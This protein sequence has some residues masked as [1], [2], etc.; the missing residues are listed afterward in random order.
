M[1]AGIPQEKTAFGLNQLCGSGLR[2][3]ALGLQ[4]I[5]NGDA[6]IIVAGGQESMSLAPHAAHLRGG[7]KMGDMKLVD[8]MLKDG[9]IDAFHGYHMGNTAENVAAKWQ[10][11]REE[12]DRFA[13]GSQNKAEAAQ[14]AGRF[15]DEIVAVHGRGPQG[16][17]R[18]RRRTNTS[19]TARPSRRWPSCKPA[20]S[21]E[22]TVTAGNASGIND[23]AAAARA[24]ERRGGREARPHAAR[25]HRLLGD[26]R[27]R[28]RD[29]G[30]RPDPGLAQGAGEGRLEGQATST[31]SRPT[32]PSPR[33]RSRSTRTWAG[34]RR[35]VNVNG[36]AIAI[37]HPI[38]A[39]GAR[40]LVDAAA[41]DGAPRRQ[42]GPRHA[43]HRRRHGHRDVA[44]SAKTAPALRFDKSAPK[45]DCK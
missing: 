45:R 29:H 19:A 32:R 33:R 26:R 31:S 16:R 18:R 20:F 11:S 41:R 14:K 24:D 34:I 30:H 6:E 25:A 42:E 7:V 10:I 2:A 4:Q 3:V 36:G 35:I 8:T 15:K 40:V 13:V 27:R 12:Q 43:L 38:G 37:G 17:H 44:S 39:S 23:G 28:S 9:L 21:K 1:K 22:G 5:A